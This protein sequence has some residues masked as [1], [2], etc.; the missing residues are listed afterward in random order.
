[1]LA[2]SSVPVLRDLGSTVAPGALL[3]LVF[4]ALMARP[5]AAQAVSR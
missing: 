3:A 2:C 5:V 4:A 1:V